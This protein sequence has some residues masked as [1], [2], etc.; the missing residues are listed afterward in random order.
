M[1]RCILLQTLLKG[2]VEPIDSQCHC[3]EVLTLSLLF[4]RCQAASCLLHKL[5]QYTYTALAVMYICWQGQA[6]T[7]AP[8]SSSLSVQSQSSFL[9]AS[10]PSN[11]FAFIQSRPR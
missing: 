9:S 8:G 2:R 6:F 4:Q 11:R 5:I 3:Q 1:T 7:T 10:T